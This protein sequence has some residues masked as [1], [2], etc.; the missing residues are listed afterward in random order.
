MFQSKRQEIYKDAY[1]TSSDVY[2]YRALT[3]SFK[4]YVRRIIV[5]AHSQLRFIR[6]ELL[7]ELFSPRN[8]EKWYKTHY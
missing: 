4:V 1:Q 8:P 7:H 2:H 5:R 3:V 6:R